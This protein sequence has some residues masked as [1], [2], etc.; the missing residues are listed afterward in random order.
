MCLAS[1]LG[2]VYKEDILND[3][4][5]NDIVCFMFIAA[6]WLYDNVQI[7]HTPSTRQIHLQPTRKKKK[8]KE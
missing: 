5:W 4:D 1:L 8:T 3:D 7:E 2:K 6:K